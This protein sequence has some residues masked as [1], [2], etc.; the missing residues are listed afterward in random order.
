MTVSLIGM[1]RSFLLCGEKRL[2]DGYHCFLARAGLGELP[3]GG[4]CSK[5]HITS[6]TN[7]YY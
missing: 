2:F 1:H 3:R 5:P 6:Q 7:Y 4:E